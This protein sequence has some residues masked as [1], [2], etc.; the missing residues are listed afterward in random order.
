MK[1]LFPILLILLAILS[2]KQKKNQVSQNESNNDPIAIA[3]IIQR[4][5][6]LSEINY[7]VD[8]VW[9]GPVPGSIDSLSGYCSF[10][11]NKNDTIIAAQYLF[12][13]DKYTTLYNGEVFIYAKPENKSAQIYNLDEYPNP[14]NRVTSSMLYHLSY[15]EVI[16]DLKERYANKPQTIVILQDTLINNNKNARIKIVEWDTLIN[17]IR[18]YQHRIIIFDKNTLLP[19]YVI[20]IN[21]TPGEVYEGQTIEATFSQFDI[22]TISTNK[23]FDL[24]SIPFQIQ[25]ITYSTD[26]QV[27]P[28]LKINDNAPRW[29]ANLINGDSISTKELNGKITLLN[30]TSVN[31]GFCLKANEVLKKIDEK[32]KYSKLAVISVYPIDKIDAIQYL[33]NK[34]NIKHSIIYKASKMQKDYLVNGFP[35]LFIINVSGKIEYYSPG[36]HDDLEKELTETIDRLLTKI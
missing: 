36:F 6:G 3:K 14:R 7:R 28:T 31:C 27:I 30:F 12:T 9:K 29:K 15:I 13:T 2:C 26:K 10:I 24:S 4:F 23:T 18:H 35:A 33:V 17:D 32:F 34:S 20:K 11:N 8:Q 1:N 25:K 5:D 22:K 19:Y 16:N 21:S